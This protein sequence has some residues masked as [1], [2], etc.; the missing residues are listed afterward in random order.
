MNHMTVKKIYTL[1]N[2]D[3]IDVD[4]SVEIIS[5]LPSDSALKRLFRI[6][7]PS[8]EADNLTQAICVIMPM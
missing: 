4:E 1:E 8:D 5:S 2:D 7:T 3:V 6:G